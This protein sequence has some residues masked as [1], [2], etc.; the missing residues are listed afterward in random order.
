MQLLEILKRLKQPILASKM[1]SKTLKGNNIVYVAWY[2]LVDLLDE[3]A[4]LDGWAW[5]IE[6]SQIGNQAIVVGKLTI[7]GED[8]TLVRQ[9]SGI[10]DIDCSSFGDPSSNAEAMALR[11]CCAKFGLGLDLWRKGKPSGGNSSEKGEI[12]KE[13]WLKRR[14]N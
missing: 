5:E 9:S 3:R 10:E 2:D 11:R 13:E 14:G 8:K 7:I 4:G 6:I 12:S 1:S